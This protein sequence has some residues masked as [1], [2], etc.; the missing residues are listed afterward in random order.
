MLL[1]GIELQEKQSQ[2]IKVYRKSLSKEPAVN[3]SL[4]ILDLNP[5]R[6]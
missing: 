5:F 2:K 1:Q 3:R 4:L 6:V